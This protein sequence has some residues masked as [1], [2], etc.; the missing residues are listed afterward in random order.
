M[1]SHFV[2]MPLQIP[3]YFLII[4][5][6]KIKPSTWKNT[7]RM[8]TS[9]QRRRIGSLTQINQEG[10][11][12]PV[13]SDTPARLANDHNKKRKNKTGKAKRYNC[14]TRSG[15]NYNTIGNVYSTY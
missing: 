6:F 5:L 9:M 14:P 15:F 13:S 11:R 1:K 3:I 7:K 12:T 10:S 8:A 2:K 4:L